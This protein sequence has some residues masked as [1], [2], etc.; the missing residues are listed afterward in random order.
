MVHRIAE[1][2]LRVP[3]SKLQYGKAGSTA[4]MALQFSTAE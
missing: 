2:M 3:E 1:Q 4:S